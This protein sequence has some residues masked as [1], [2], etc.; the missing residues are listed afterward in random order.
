[1]TPRST[2]VPWQPWMLAV[3]AMIAIALGTVARGYFGLDWFFNTDNLTDSLPLALPFLVAAGVM[4]G[5]NRWT[6]GRTWLLAGAWLLALHGVLD[7]S[8]ELQ[9]ASLMTDGQAF[10]WAAA[11]PWLTARYV[12]NGASQT[13]AFG[14]LAIGMLRSPA[15]KWSRTRRWVAALIAVAVGATAT[16]LLVVNLTVPV[17]APGRTPV[18]LI[19]LVLYSG[20]VA[21]AGALAI[22]GLRAAPRRLPIPELLIAASAAI[23]AINRGL[24]WWLL[25][26]VPPDS[27]L[28]WTTNARFADAALLALAVGFGSGALFGTPEDGQVS[29]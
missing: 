15:A 5:V 20:F 1:M 29:A 2:Q 7:V 3:A 25:G 12:L 22:A 21:A 10:G 28:L 6:P 14:A 13:F 18:L 17:T 19:G 9:L 11:E 4:V 24:A 27:A 23:Y 8:F 16:G 26:I